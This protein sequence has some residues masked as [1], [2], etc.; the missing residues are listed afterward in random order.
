MIP[1][2]YERTETTFRSNG[3]GA[4][5]D[6]TEAI[7]HQVRNGEN[8]A[9]IRMP[10][11]GRHAEDIQVGRIVVM[12]TDHRLRRQPYDIVQV[13][14]DL[15]GWLSIQLEHVRHRLRYSVLRP[16]TASGIADLFAKL[17]ANASAQ[18]IEGNIFTFETDL[19][20]TSSYT[21]P[22]YQ[23][24]LD[25]LGGSDG[26]VLDVYGGFYEWDGFTVRLLKRR[27]QDNGVVVRYAKNLTALDDETEDTNVVNG[28]FP[29]WTSGSTTVTAGTIVTAG[30]RAL[31]P[32]RR[33]QVVDFSGDF[34]SQPTATQL[35]N[36][37]SAWLAKRSQTPERSLSAAY[38]P[39]YQSIEYKDLA[40]AEQVALDDTIHLVVPEPFNV[41]ATARVVETYF[42]NLRSRYQSVVIGTIRPTITD[43]IRSVK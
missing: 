38:V 39:L 29:I 34:Q 15:S 19:T 9:M 16:F 24:V 27:G 12:D 26:S 17:D 21:V 2:L 32:Y 36:A 1:T 30:D 42:D 13:N 18:Y 5:A 8:T 11:D 14:K 28:A 43:A 7:A 20:S 23:S 35:Q 22:G 37:A 3:L 4:L 10:I 25:T 6:C 31:Y 41:N 40:N 33:T